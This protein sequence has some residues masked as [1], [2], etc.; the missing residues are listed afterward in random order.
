MYV[1]VECLFSHGQIVLLNM[2]NHLSAQSVHAI[3]CLGSWSAQ[4]FSKDSDIQKLAV[5][6]EIEGYLNIVLE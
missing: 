1:N 5:M 6:D 2:Y 4:G 3:L